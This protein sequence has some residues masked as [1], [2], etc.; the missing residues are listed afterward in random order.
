MFS[1][2]KLGIF[3]LTF[4]ITIYNLPVYGSSNLVSQGNTKLEMIPY[5]ELDN[6]PDVKEFIEQH[7]GFE[8]IEE[9]Q[10][11]LIELIYAD[12]IEESEGAISKE[13]IEYFND[14]YSL[15]ES[16]EKRV[17]PC[18][19]ILFE[20]DYNQ[21][22]VQ[23]GN[24]W[25]ITYHVSNSDFKIKL[26]NISTTSLKDPI[27]S[28]KGNVYLY[29][30]SRRNWV[31][32]KQDTI[33]KTQVKNGTIYTW[34][35]PATYVKE[36]FEYE[37]VVVEDGQTWKYNNVNEEDLVRYNFEAGPFNNLAAN[38]GERHH[39]VSRDALDATGYNSNIAYAIRMMYD[40]HIKTGSW[41]SYTSSKEYREEEKRLIKA[42]KFKE[43]LQK[44]VDDLKAKKECEGTG[45]SLCSKYYEQ[46]VSCLAMY[47]KMFGLR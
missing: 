43:L 24:A 47:E 26:A 44:E 22:G 36:K 35:I 28:I 31:K 42:M 16:L 45:I 6:H 1:L 9:E 11:G 15:H 20:R 46:V 29:R 34:S 17:E 21:R 37:I 25:L 27:D 10:E 5:S 7:N 8:I 13:D 18:Q 3:I 19:Q 12:I 14:E 30:L 39:F 33:S 32:E 23:I 40:D 38:G 4:L 2:K 41:G